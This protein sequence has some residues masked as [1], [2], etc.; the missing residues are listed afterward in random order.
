MRTDKT[1]EN[2]LQ[3]PVVPYHYLSDDTRLEKR[4]IVTV[5]RNIAEN[6][7]F[8]APIRI[9]PINNDHTPTHIP[10]S[11]CFSIQPATGTGQSTPQSSSVFAGNLHHPLEIYHQDR[12]DTCSRL[13]AEVEG[14]SDKRCSLSGKRCQN[15]SAYAKRKRD[16]EREHYQNDPC[17]A[18]RKRERQRE[19][20]KD[21]ANV[22]RDR[23]RSREYQRERRKDPAYLERERERKRERYQTDPAYAERERKRHRER[24]RERYQADPA[25]AER[26]RER[27]KQYRQ[28][29]NS[30]KNSGDLPLTSNL[31]D[32]AQSSSK[33]SEG[34]APRFSV[35][36]LKE[37]L[38]SRS[39]PSQP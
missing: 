6:Q 7:L 39:P 32:T 38:Q 3:Q 12:T 34:T 33:N 19:R 10:V 35:V 18:E 28:S 1:T 16:R 5:D 30:T 29:D 22:K 37:Y 14:E 4:S 24:Q 2:C 8:Y 21:P 26:E 20:R 11:E 31:T 23:E 36:K 25:Y 15:D 9:N 13:T 17:Y 27:K